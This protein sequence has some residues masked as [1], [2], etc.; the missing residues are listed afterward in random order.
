MVSGK[1]LSPFIR[2]CQPNNHLDMRVWRENLG[3]IDL[4][5]GDNVTIPSPQ[6]N[7]WK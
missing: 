7:L 6:L 1:L 3:K 2:F 4:V 5:K